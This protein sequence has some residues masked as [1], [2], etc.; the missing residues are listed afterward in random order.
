MLVNDNSGM[1]FDDPDLFEWPRDV[2][3]QRALNL[4]DAQA[5]ELT[6][7]GAPPSGHRPNDR[8]YKLRPTG[9]QRDLKQA[10]H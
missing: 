10:R 5:A 9:T 2:T 3:P 8:G 1:T 7:A 4:L 6:A